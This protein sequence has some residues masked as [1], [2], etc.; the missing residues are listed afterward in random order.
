MSDG[1]EGQASRISFPRVTTQRHQEKGKEKAAKP[2]RPSPSG[3]KARSETAS[4]VH[5]HALPANTGDLRQDC[6]R[7][8][9]SDK[10][11]SRRVLPLAPNLQGRRRSRAGQTGRCRFAREARC[12]GSQRLVGGAAHRRG[13][14][15]V[16]RLGCVCTD[17]LGKPFLQ[18]ALRS[19]PKWSLEST[20][21]SSSKSV[22]FS[23]EDRPVRKRLLRKSTRQANSPRSLRPS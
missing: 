19:R 13:R 16:A 2:S 15:V 11:P 17:G 7:A 14:I 23:A 12:R 1:K 21:W 8:C 4:V 22:S 5:V 18:D 3:R 9:S 6:C 10:F 20:F